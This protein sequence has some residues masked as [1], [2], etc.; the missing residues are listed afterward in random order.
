MAIGNI[1][2][3]N[4]FIFTLVVCLVFKNHVSTEV[5]L[6]GTTDSPPSHSRRLP[7]TYISTS[8]MHAATKVD[9]W[10]QKRDRPHYRF[11]LYLLGQS[12]ESA[13]QTGIDPG[14]VVEKIDKDG[15]GVKAGIQPGDILLG[16]NRG[17]IQGSFESPF[18]L[19]AIEIEQAPRGMVTLEGGRGAKKLSWVVG[20]DVWGIEARPNFSG[21]ALLCYDEYQ[22]ALPEKPSD[23]STCWT[24]LEHVGQPSWLDTWLLVHSAEF[25]AERKSWKEADELFQAANNVA[26]A[27]GRAETRGYLL[28]L[29][30][31]TYV[32]RQDFLQAEKHYQQSLAADS[33]PNEKNLRA[34]VSLQKLGALAQRRGEFGNSDEYLH[35]A[36]TIQDEMA[37]G[38]LDSARI[39]R[40]LGATSFQTGDLSKADECWRKSLLIVQK[41]VP[42]SSEHAATMINVATVAR[43][44][45]DL[46]ASEVQFRRALEIEQRLFPGGRGVAISLSGLG[47]IARDRGD[48]VQA[49]RYAREAHSVSPQPVFH[50]HRR[51]LPHV[52]GSGEPYG[53][54]L[55]SISGICAGIASGNQSGTAGNNAPNR[56][57]RLGAFRQ[58]SAGRGKTT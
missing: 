5:E 45:G 15:E 31:R 56:I 8:R 55:K 38:S 51:P 11:S 6:H 12:Q 18:D 4:G 10:R 30:A 49:D 16:W 28:R 35:R 13:L 27:V 32:D 24:R 48:L 37:P 58:G 17:E 3:L 22:R 52:A 39:L 53:K 46:A 50:K 43:N 23:I 47:N 26:E 20:P 42:G 44:R 34:A 14:I 19:A 40:G 54:I 29:W 9:E 25:F 1:R 2:R 36:L 41:L 57:R 21:S 7:A 33:Q